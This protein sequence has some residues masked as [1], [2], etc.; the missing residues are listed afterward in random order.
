MDALFWFLHLPALAAWILLLAPH[1]VR[2]IAAA[3]GAGLLLALAYCA[4]F[5]AGRGASTLV[6]DYSLEG[7]AEFFAVPGLRLAGWTHYLVLDLWAG[8]WESEEAARRGM[9]SWQLRLSLL[10]TACVGPFGLVVFL[11]L[12]WIR[13]ILQAR[14]GQS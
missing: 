5:F 7:I 10:L 13:G 8:I 1:D 6:A 9:P 4:L 11:L 2:R 3:K 12:G 14:P